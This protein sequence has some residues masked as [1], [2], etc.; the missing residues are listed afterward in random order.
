MGF[1]TAYSQSIVKEINDI[2]RKNNARV[3]VAAIYKNM[4]YTVGNKARYPLMSTFKFHVAVAAMRI[5]ER[6]NISLDRM[7][8]IEENQMHK[9]TYSP[10][11]DKYP[12]QRIHI[13]Y[14]DII[15]YTVS[16]SDNNTCDWLIDFAGGINKVDSCIK[17]LG[18][19][20]FNLTETEYTMHEDI[21]NCYNNWS[22]PLSV[23]KL[24]NKVYTEN[25][26]SKEHFLFI[27]Q[28]M[29]D[30]PT[31]IDK[32]KAGLPKNIKLGHKT[33]H[34][35]RTPEGIQIAETDAGVIYLPDGEKC[36]I[37]VLIKDSK[38][39]DK[40]NAKIMADISE[41]VFRSITE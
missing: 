30:S 29:L 37:A 22:T 3:G 17:S 34:S 13:S 40:K 27:E 7:V 24:M 21:T 15:E 18:I 14:R 26:L 20:D 16:L 38:E 8:Y 23:V 2:I 35:D 4:T 10:L 28:A 41:A 5:M 9:N 19:E 12:D 11:R 31:G 6:E 1:I 33:G 32:L 39:S 25:I 36:Y